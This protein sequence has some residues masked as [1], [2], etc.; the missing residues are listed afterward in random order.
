MPEF[1]ERFKVNSEEWVA[2]VVIGCR[3]QAL[4]DKT[5][6]R[7][8]ALRYGAMEWSGDEEVVSVYFA[9]SRQNMEITQERANG[10][11]HEAVL[12]A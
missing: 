4:Q 12:Y 8:L 7:D 9:G 2:E 3:G 6:I 11:C 1:V 5:A 10:F